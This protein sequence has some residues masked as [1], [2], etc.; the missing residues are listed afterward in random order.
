MSRGGGGGRGGGGIPIRCDVF[1]KTKEQKKLPFIATS[2]W[3]VLAVQWSVKYF[4]APNSP[5]FREGGGEKKRA[6]Y[7]PIAFQT[8]VINKFDL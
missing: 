3:I 7:E 5:L 1:R 8:N 2:N 6:N 4:F